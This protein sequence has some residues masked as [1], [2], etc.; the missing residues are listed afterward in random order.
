[1]FFSLLWLLVGWIFLGVHLAL[2]KGALVCVSGDV[3]DV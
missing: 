2:P 3:F 1:M